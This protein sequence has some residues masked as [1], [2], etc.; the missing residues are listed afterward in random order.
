MST[1]R[2]VIALLKS[3]LEGEEQQFFSVAL[4]MAAHEARQGHTKVAQ[5]I[6]NIIDKAKE[7]KSVIEYKA[8]P[9]PLVQPKGELVN[10]V[11][12]C[13]SDTRLTDMVLPSTLEQRLRRILIEHINPHSAPQLSQSVITETNLSNKN[14]IILFIE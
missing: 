11:S 13:Y 8:S 7:R 12:V 6:Q 3:Y 1:S 2:H 14:K 4:Q 9:V 10:L 5:E